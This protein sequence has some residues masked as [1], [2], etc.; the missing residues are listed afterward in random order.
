MN[1]LKTIKQAFIEVLV[2]THLNQKLRRNL[3]DVE[4]SSLRILQSTDRGY[5][6][7]VPNV[8]YGYYSFGFNLISVTKI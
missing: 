2:I 1:S 4:E 6:Y 5:D 7:I 3:T 8:A